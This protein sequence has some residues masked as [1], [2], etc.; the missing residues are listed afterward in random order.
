MHW[1]KYIALA[2]S[3]SLT[4]SRR[5]FQITVLKMFRNFY[6]NSKLLYSYNISNVQ[7]YDFNLFAFSL[8][9]KIH[10]TE[11]CDQILL[12]FGSVELFG[13]QWG[14]NS[15]GHVARSTCLISAGVSRYM[16]TNFCT[17]FVFLISLWLFIL[18]KNR[19][20]AVFGMDFCAILRSLFLRALLMRWRA[21]IYQWTKV[22]SW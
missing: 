2:T 22:F 9:L 12:E 11:N 17:L 16:N 5:P 15:V 21:V 8:F 3:F 6:D 10:N 18:K 14:L 7:H 1:Q 20:P 4:L 19:R 13:R